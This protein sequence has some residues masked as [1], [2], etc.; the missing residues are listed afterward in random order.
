MLLLLAAASAVDVVAA[1]AT[2]TAVDA[3]AKNCCGDR[4]GPTWSIPDRGSGVVIVGVSVAD[5][6]YCCG[7]CCL[8]LK[9]ANDANDENADVEATANTPTT[10]RIPNNQPTLLLLF[11]NDTDDDDDDNCAKCKKHWL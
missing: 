3:D 8:S 11:M 9:D 2:V 1:T 5:E 4:A 7:C 6:W 10:N